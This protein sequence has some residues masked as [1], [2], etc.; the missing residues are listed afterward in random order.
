MT[1]NSPK[2]LRWF[3]V[4]LR[5]LLLLV[6]LTSV[7]CSF[8]LA[9]FRPNVS[10]SYLGRGTHINLSGSEE[11]HLRVAIT[12]K[13]FFPIWYPDKKELGADFEYRSSPSKPDLSKLDDV[14]YDL[15]YDDWCELR[16]GE[17]FAFQV[18]DG[19][20]SVKEYL[21]EQ[22]AGNE[23]DLRVLEQPLWL[24]VTLPIR[25]WRGRQT[26]CWHEPFRIE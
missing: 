7:A 11:N 10:F 19:V 12:N 23:A 9:P 15:G 2:H 8:L 16:P 4:R 21:M 22:S 13:A 17:T 3:Q 14:P 25:D 20:E 6:V 18:I 26:I 24:S 5:T 1:K